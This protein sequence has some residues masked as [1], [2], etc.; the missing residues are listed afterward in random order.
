MQKS[1]KT[2]KTFAKNYYEQN[3]SKKKKNS[4][5]GKKEK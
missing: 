2:S 5:A 3:C 4:T 1:A